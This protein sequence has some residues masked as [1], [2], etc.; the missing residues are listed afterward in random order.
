MMSVSREKSVDAEDL[1]M[2]YAWL[3]RW[4]P[5]R[6]LATIVLMIACASGIAPRMA[7]ASYDDDLKTAKQIADW[8]EHGWNYTNGVIT[9]VEFILGVHQTPNALTLQSTRTTLVDVVN[10]RHDQDLVHQVEG[11]S[12]NYYNDLLVKVQSQLCPNGPNGC[13]PDTPLSELVAASPVLAQLFI[14]KLTL[15]QNTATDLLYA[16]DEPLRMVSTPTTGQR[17][18]SVIA[19]YTML[20]PIWTSL[21]K[22]EGDIYPSERGGI[23][24]LIGTTLPHIQQTLLMVAGAYMLRAYECGKSTAEQPVFFYSPVGTDPTFMHARPLYYYYSLD[25][26]GSFSGGAPGYWN[27]P[28]TKLALDSLQNVVNSNP[29]S[30]VWAENAYIWDSTG[31]YN[32]ARCAVGWITRVRY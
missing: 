14:T 6:L 4:L 17:V 5:V 7:Q 1:A 29:R 20:L 8:A 30:I 19:S 10:A 18:A 24:D 11:L 21:Q 16:L 2:K 27:Q 31:K 25:A 15:L 13:S 9:A 26:N 12:K 28:L 3:V 23:D 32:S 22:L